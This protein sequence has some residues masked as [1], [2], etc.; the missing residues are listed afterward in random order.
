MFIRPKDIY[1]GALPSGN[2]IAALNMMR[3]YEFTGNTKLKDNVEEMLYNFG[4]DINANPLGHGY[5]LALF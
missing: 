4:G 1:D 2:S 5:I 3:L